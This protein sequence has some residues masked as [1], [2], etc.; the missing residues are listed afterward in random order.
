MKDNFSGHSSDYAKFRPEYPAEVYTFLK[1][2]LSGSD[3]AWDC[4]TGNGQ[5]ASRLADFFNL[6]EATDISQPQLKNA[7]QKNAIH[8]SLQPAEKVNFPDAVF[9]LVIC[10]Q[11]V[12]WFDFAAF[13][14]EA[15]RCLKKGGL[16]ALM[17]YG[18]IRGNQ[19]FNQVMDHFYNN[20]IGPYWD[21]E[22]RHLDNEYQDIPFP[23]EE[24]P[25]PKLDLSL[26]WDITH[27][28]GYLRTWSAVKHY[29]KAHGKDPVQIVEKDLRN[30]F[31]NLGS[32]KFPI[33][34]RAGRA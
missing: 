16:L 15:T 12:H 31:E 22:R 24:I 28:L 17:G 9:D 7:I 14:S 6:V 13:F 3:C 32:V 26:K 33:I 19:A 27:L 8:Y 5:V 30:S 34:L 4:G 21:P 23:F 20:I 18:L 25:A 11:S 1:E 29:E 2:N 10:G